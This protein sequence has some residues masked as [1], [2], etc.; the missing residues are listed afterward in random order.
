MK[1]KYEAAAVAF[2]LYFG[3][4]VVFELWDQPLELN[5]QYFILQSIV[6]LVG[7]LYGSRLF[8]TAFLL[9]SIWFFAM[10]FDA[11][12]YNFYGLVTLIYAAHEYTIAALNILIIGTIIGGNDGSG[13]TKRVSSCNYSRGLA[14]IQS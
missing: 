14:N 3:S 7:V 4:V 5:Y 10:A 6:S 1:N 11:F 9:Q 2:L 12:L 8:R 13:L